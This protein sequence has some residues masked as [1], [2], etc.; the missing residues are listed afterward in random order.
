MEADTVKDPAFLS[1][2][3]LARSIRGRRIG[4]R[5]LLEHYVERIDRFNPV[6]NAVVA[7][8]L[9]SAR[10]RADEADRALDR[11]QAWGPLHGLPMTVKDSFDVVGMPTTWGMLELKH[12]VPAQNAVVTD[13]LVGA[14]AIVFGKTNVPEL[15][16]DWQ[17]FNEVY[18]TTN[19]PWD[20]SRVPGG[21]S[22][23]AAAA[24][25]AG[26]TGLEFGSDIG[27]SIRNPAHY[28]GVY[29]HKPTYGIVPVRGQAL[30]G[31]I[32]PN[33]ISV[34][35][36]LARSADDLKLALGVAA[37]PDAL[38]ARAWRLSLPRP[39][40]RRLEDH[41]IAVMLEDPNCEVDGALADRLAG[42]VDALARTGARVEDRARPAIDTT[43]SHEVYL[44]LLRAVTTARQP[45]ADFDKAKALADTLDGGDRS[46]AAQVARA[47][48]QYH[49][50]WI[51]VNEER[52]HLRMR[53]AEFFEDYDVLLCPAAASAAFPHNHAGTRADRTIEVNGHQMPEVDELFWA[54]L[55]AV[56]Y[57]PSTV[58]PIGLTGSG[59]P[60]GVQIIGPHLG[61]LATIHFARLLGRAFGGFVPP[62][63]YM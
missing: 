18:G 44:R 41:R 39:R 58:A 8:D 16:A 19:N 45:M 24:L 12:N 54:G 59:L 36:P 34:V 1:A 47:T 21:S 62:P 61:D 51:A 50:D 32:A 17:T 63:G 43:R 46:Y 48:V 33:D 4:S 53:W 35:G 55:S 3:Q 10:R 29:G 57:L 30:P 2:S 52:A 5:E 7:R 20:I 49:R 25:A 15:L 31:I 37:G 40:H 60:V 27:A 9:E 23:G 38:D 28:C 56:V 42:L 6:L 13:R 11:R 14:G 26:L 22:G